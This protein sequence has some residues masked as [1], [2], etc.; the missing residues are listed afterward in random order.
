MNNQPP[1]NLPFEPWYPEGSNPNDAPGYYFAVVGELRGEVTRQIKVD[2]N[3]RWHWLITI[4]AGTDD[5][6]WEDWTNVRETK[7]SCPS[8]EAAMNAANEAYRKMFGLQ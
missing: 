7:Q 2:E 1:A 8:A 5:D 3:E 4:F 6:G